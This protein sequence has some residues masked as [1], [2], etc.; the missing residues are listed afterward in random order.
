MR[1]DIKLMGVEEDDRDCWRCEI[2]YELVTE[3]VRELSQV[4]DLVTC[5]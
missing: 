5:K 2:H 1:E 4:F 3:A